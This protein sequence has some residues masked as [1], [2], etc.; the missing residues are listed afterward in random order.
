M[1]LVLV[2]VPVIVGVPVVGMQVGMGVV[3]V[4]VVDVMFV[5]VQRRTTHEF[6]EWIADDTV[7]SRVAGTAGMNIVRVDLGR[8]TD[9]GEVPDVMGDGLVM[10]VAAV[11]VV[12]VPVT[13]PSL[14]TSTDCRHEHRQTEGR[15]QEPADDAQVVQH[16]LSCQCGRDRQ[17]ESEQ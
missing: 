3:G 4:L 8:R 10:G 15:D 11:F 5:V 1:V 12:V 7:A 14:V 9:D 6:V 2:L 17:P 16:G 13:Q